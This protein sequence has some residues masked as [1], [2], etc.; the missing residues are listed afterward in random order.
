MLT[1]VPTPA[2]P[3]TVLAATDIRKNFG[4]THA[5]RGVS[6][7]FAAAEIHAVMGENGAGKSTFVKILAG[8]YPA[9]SYAGRLMLLG[10]PVAIRSIRDAESAGIFFVPQ[11]LQSVPALSVAENL[12][13]NREPQ[14]FGLLDPIRLARE[15]RSLLAEFR[16]DCDPFQP[17]RSLTPAQQQLVLI[18]RAMA[19]GVRVLA[20][21][22]PTAA[23]TST[24]TGILFDHLLG[25]KQRGIAIIYISHRLNE[26]AT[27]ADRISVLRDGMLVDSVERGDPEEVGR[28]VVR[29]M[30]GHEIRLQQ[31]AIRQVG[32]PKLAVQGVRLGQPDRAD[33]ETGPVAFKLHAG[34]VLGV[35][36]SAGCG[37]DELVRMLVGMQALPPGGTVL[38]NEQPVTLADPDDA[39]HAGLGYVPGDRQRLASFP[40]LSIAA[41]IDVLVLGR[42]STAGIIRPPAQMRLVQRYFDRLRVRAASSDEPLR[43]L[44]GGNQ[45][46]VILSRVLARDPPILLFHE[47]TQG[48]DIATKDEI[49]AIADDLVRHGKAI[50]L[51]SSDLEEIFVLSDTIVVL[52]AGRMVGEWPKR[53]V[54][55][56]QV[57]AAA[58]AGRRHDAPAVA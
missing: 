9:G 53:G 43:K 8:V 47:P 35:F 50:L 1:A 16:I 10:K 37:S 55:Q 12:F 28:R 33:A 4:A 26:V 15:A 54:T 13:L 25:L 48:V 46:K 36:G 31:H 24:E 5:L 58:T 51:V 49:Y 6:I 20:L 14:R 52:C 57:L 38:I 44:S 19:R 29:A 7:A 45:Q 21:D 41:N 42:L 2:A 17:M 11:D 3:E 40:L 56:E 23:L 18:T 22:E 27:I 32:A 39:L 30:V 34:Q